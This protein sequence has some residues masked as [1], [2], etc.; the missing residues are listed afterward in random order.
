MES[1]IQNA[2]KSGKPVFIFF[3]MTG[4]G[5]CIQAM[6]EW[7][8]ISSIPNAFDIEQSSAPEL[9][10]KYKI[11]GFPTLLFIKGNHTKVYEGE[12]TKDKMEAW[13]RS[14]LEQ[15]GGRGR[16]TKKRTRRRRLRTRGRATPCHNLSRK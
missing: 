1:K 7:K 13:M 4:C 6:P 12:R 10:Q 8:K 11:M 16:G 15:T 14:H 5:F 9:L 3:H 2:I